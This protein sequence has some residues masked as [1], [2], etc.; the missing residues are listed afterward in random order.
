M[1]FDLSSRSR[2]NDAKNHTIENKTMNKIPIV[3]TNVACVMKNHMSTLQSHDR[4]NFSGSG[5]RP[6]PAEERIAIS[7]SRG[8]WSMLSGI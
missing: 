4:M 8:L 5:R 3:D 2:S 6:T 7:M 1:E